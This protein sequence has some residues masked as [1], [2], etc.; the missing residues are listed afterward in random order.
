MS[1]RP[2]QGN[3]PGTTDRRI[4]PLERA[5]RKYAELKEE[6]LR[7]KRED[8]LQRAALLK[9]MKEHHKQ[10][11]ERPGLS[12]EVVAETENVRVRL[13]AEPS[14]IPDPLDRDEAAS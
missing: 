5:A 7:L 3:L 1:T 13:R 11:Y 9:L 6:R 2:R 8:V 10:V 4:A 12:V 14:A